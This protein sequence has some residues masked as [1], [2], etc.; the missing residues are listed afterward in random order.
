MTIDCERYLT[1]LAQK[2]LEIVQSI[3]HWK[4]CL[5]MVF[6]AE[7]WAN[8]QKANHSIRFNFILAVVCLVFYLLTSFGLAIGEKTVE[9]RSYLPTNPSCRPYCVE[10]HL[11]YFDFYLHFWIIPTATHRLIR[12]Y[13]RWLDLV[14]SHEPSTR[15]GSIMS[16]MRR[17]AQFMILNFLM[18]AKVDRF[19]F[20]LFHNPITDWKPWMNL[21]HFLLTIWHRFPDF[22]NWTTA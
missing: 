4:Y 17:L 13:Y 8:S 10:N 2:M 16:S 6:S 22:V 21:Y 5:L 18:I 19:C 9:S 7:D 12:C 15:Q 3:S 14:E 11:H 20:H 1:H